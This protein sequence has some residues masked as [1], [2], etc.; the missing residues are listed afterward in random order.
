M[1]LINLLLENKNIFKIEIINS[2]IK[3]EEIIHKQYG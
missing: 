2:F 1:I 3:F